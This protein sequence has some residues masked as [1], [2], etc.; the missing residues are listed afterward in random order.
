MAEAELYDYYGQ[1]NKDGAEHGI[2]RYYLHS[3]GGLYEGEYKNGDWYEGYWK[4][5]K[6]HGWGRYV[7][8]AEKKVKEKEGV[9]ANDRFMN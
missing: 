7:Y 5:N 9:W 4:R 2:G 8:H 3:E 6:S 1:I